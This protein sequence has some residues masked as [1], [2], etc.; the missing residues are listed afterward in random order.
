MSIDRMRG[1]YDRLPAVCCCLPV[2]IG[3]AEIRQSITR[4]IALLPGEGVERPDFALEKADG[5]HITGVRLRPCTGAYAGG[6][7]LLVNVAYTLWYSDGES[8][9][10]QA[11]AVTFVLAAESMAA[12][13]DRVKAFESG[14]HGNCRRSR[15][16]RLD[17]QAEAYGEII[18]PCTGALILDVGAFFLF[19]RECRLPLD[20]PSPEKS[21]DAGRDIFRCAQVPPADRWEEFI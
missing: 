4:N 5:F 20:I 11:D 15:Y 19:R 14:R 9:R 1:E 3:Q 6:A 21:A 12:P 10:S 16:F 7:E 2:V 8:R 18:C 13:P 17:A